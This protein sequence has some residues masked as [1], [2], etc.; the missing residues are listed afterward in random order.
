[1]DTPEKKVFL[2]CLLPAVKGVNQ[3]CVQLREIRITGLPLCVAGIENF[4]KWPFS[5]D[6]FSQPVVFIKHEYLKSK[7]FKGLES[8]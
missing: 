6:A 4:E 7:K 2:R 1:M 8:I 5:S 3:R